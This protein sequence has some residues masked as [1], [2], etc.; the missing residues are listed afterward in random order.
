MLT[1]ELLE[2][3]LA[4]IDVNEHGCWLWQGATNAHG[5]GNIG[6]ER[7]TRLTHRVV[8][9]LLVGDPGPVLDHLCREPACCNPDH[10]E[11]VTQLENIVRGNVASLRLVCARGHWLLG[12]NVRWQKRGNGRERRCRTCDDA[13][14]S[15]WRDAHRDEVN[16]QRRARYAARKGER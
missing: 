4:R 1:D 14:V 3:I 15:A 2:R 12:D 13:R 5:Y 11:P 10:L 7:R 16:A 8:Y 6:V 9:S